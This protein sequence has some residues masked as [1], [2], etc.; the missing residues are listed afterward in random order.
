LD[1]TL[2]ALLNCF[3]GNAYS[4]SH[5]LLDTQVISW[6]SWVRHWYF[7]TPLHDPPQQ[8]DTS[9]SSTNY[10]LD[11]RNTTTCAEPCMRNWYSIAHAGLSGSDCIE[12]GMFNGIVSITAPPMET[13]IAH[14]RPHAPFF[15]PPLHGVDFSALE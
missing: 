6:K 9:P 5:P 15:P 7:R 8:L 10:F 4:S 14:S 11:A 3:Q 12:S 2:I 1:R 13:R